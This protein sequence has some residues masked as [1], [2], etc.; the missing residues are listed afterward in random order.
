LNA[1][2]ALGYQARL[3]GLIVRQ[4]HDEKWGSGKQCFHDGIGPTV[5][6]E[7]VHPLQELPLRRVSNNDAIVLA[8]GNR[9]PCGQG[10]RAH[11]QL[12]AQPLRRRVKRGD[13]IRKAL[14]GVNAAEGRVHDLPILAESVPGKGRLITPRTKRGRGPHQS[15]VRGQRDFAHEIARREDDVREGR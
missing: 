12:G 4:W 6:K 14:P 8:I 7:G 10:F 2:A 9:T 15:H 3:Q 13:D 11:Y 1:N 5:G